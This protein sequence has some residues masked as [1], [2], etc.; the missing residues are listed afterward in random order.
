MSMTL[1]KSKTCLRREWRG[2]DRCEISQPLYIQDLAEKHNLHEVSSMQTNTHGTKHRLET[3]KWTRFILAEQKHHWQFTMV[4]KRHTTRHLVFCELFLEI[5]KL[6]WT[7]ILQSSI[8]GSQMSRQHSRK[9]YHLQTGIKRERAYLKQYRQA[10][11]L[12][13]QWLGQR[14]HR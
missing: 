5:L 13:G 3:S 1:G 7:A 10:V 9:S 6:L 14:N 4:G 8:A 12:Y 2:M 11:N